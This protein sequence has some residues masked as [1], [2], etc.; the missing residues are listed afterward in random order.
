[1]IL[2]LVLQL[3]YS[4]LF[5][6]S[7]NCSSCVFTVYEIERGN[8]WRQ[9]KILDLVRDDLIIKVLSSRAQSYRYAEL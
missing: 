7:V 5:P 8:L 4:R 1:M 2:E 6:Q 3:K 9:I